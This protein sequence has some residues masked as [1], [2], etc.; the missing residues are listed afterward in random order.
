MNHV[1]IYTTPPF[2]NN[3]CYGDFG[4]IKIY[5]CF[6]S[7]PS[8]DNISFEAGGVERLRIDNVTG[9]QV[10][11]RDTTASILRVENSTAAASQVA[12]I[13]LAPKALGPN[14]ILP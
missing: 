8:D 6:G 7:F 3:Y 4:E 11:V 13:D 5:W 1:I 10:I 12:M 9:N 2:L 14:S